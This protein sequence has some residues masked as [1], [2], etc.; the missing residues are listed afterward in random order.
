MKRM[1]WLALGVTVGALV[2][3]KLSTAAEKVGPQGLSRSLQGLADAVRDFADEVCFLHEGRVLVV[4]HVF[5]PDDSRQALEVGALHPAHATAMGKVLLAFRPPEEVQRLLACT[6]LIQHTPHTITN[7]DRLRFALEQIRRA[8]YGTT[9]QEF[10]LS[11]R[12]AAAPVRDA[13]GAVVAAI[14][15][16][17]SATRVDVDTLHKEFVPQ[18][19]RTAERITRALGYARDRAGG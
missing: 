18:L 15:I 5:R 9:E 3:R 16:S 14:N 19:L 2:V 1:F 6:P 13:S 11:V 8:G 7:L 4:H 12:S 17:T 10:E